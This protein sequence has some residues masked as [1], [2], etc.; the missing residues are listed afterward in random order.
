M[1]SERSSAK[2]FFCYHHSVSW[3]SHDYHSKTALVYSSS[4]GFLA[5]HAIQLAHSAMLGLR[6]HVRYVFVAIFRHRLHLQA[7]YESN[8]ALLST[9]ASTVMH[10][11]GMAQTDRPQ[12][13]AGVQMM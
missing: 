10:W 4:S 12:D 8:T 3:S 13:C 6:T 1:A 7:A 5:A 11:L 2:S 9:D